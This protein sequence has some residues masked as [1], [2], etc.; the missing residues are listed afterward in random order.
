MSTSINNQNIAKREHA[1]VIEVSK[2]PECKH[3]ARL[4]NIVED[5]DK[6]NIVVVACLEQ[7]G[8]EWTVYAG[9]PDLTSLRANYPYDFFKD[10]FIWLCENVRDHEQV[11]IMGELLPKEAALE[12]FP[13]WADKPYKEDFNAKETTEGD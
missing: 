4:A 8:R 6:A 13:D 10:D 5:Q 2:L 1:K 9:Y 12:L 11:L 3:K 7:N